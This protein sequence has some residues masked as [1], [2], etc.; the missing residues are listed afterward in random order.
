LGYCVQHG[1]K[2]SQNLQISKLDFKIK[3]KWID[4]KMLNNHNRK[5]TMTKRYHAKLSYNGSIQKWWVHALKSHYQ[6]NY[7]DI[8][9]IIHPGGWIKCNAHIGVIICCNYYN[10]CYMMMNEQL[11]MFKHKSNYINHKSLFCCALKPNTKKH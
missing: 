9:M 2:W 10:F 5:M 1:L 7:N 6:F 8:F 3:I 11:T 4:I